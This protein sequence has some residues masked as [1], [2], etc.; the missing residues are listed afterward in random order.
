M[1]NILGVFKS[2]PAVT[3]LL[4]GELMIISGC[5]KVLIDDMCFLI[6]YV[7]T[8]EV[9]FFCVQSLVLKVTLCYIQDHSLFCSQVSAPP[10]LVFL[11]PFSLTFIPSHSSFLFSFGCSSCVSLSFSFLV[12]FVFLPFSLLPSF[13]LPF[14]LISFSFLVFLSS[15]VPYFFF[16]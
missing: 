12:C 15:F 7:I 11:L 5:V 3:F 4:S 8:F 10:S 14:F 13:H 6:F 9:S 2:P 1:I 16:L